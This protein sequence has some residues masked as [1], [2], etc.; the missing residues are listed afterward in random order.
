MTFSRVKLSDLQGSGI[1]FG[2]ELNHR[3]GGGGFHFFFQ[4]LDP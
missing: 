2:H 1:K 4:K 3:V